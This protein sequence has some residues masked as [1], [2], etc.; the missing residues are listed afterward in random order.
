MTPTLKC[1]IPLIVSLGVGTVIVRVDAQSSQPAHDQSTQPSADQSTQPPVTEL[2]VPA[3][4]TSF[5][6]TGDD[7]YKAYCAA[8]HGQSGKGDGPLAR[9]MKKR[10]PD[11]TLLARQNGGLFPSALAYKIIDGRQVTPGHGGP[12]MPT[13]GTVFKASQGG[14]SEEAVKG[15]IEALV[16][17]LESLQQRSS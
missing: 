14:P 8:C 10:P 4:E 1:L 6:G 2:S 9:N 7:L 17:Y 11:L 15:R 12:D 16:K 13:W 5:T 3:Q